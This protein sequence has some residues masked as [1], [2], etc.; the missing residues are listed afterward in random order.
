MNI[1]SSRCQCRIHYFVS[2]QLPSVVD[3]DSEPPGFLEPDCLRTLGSDTF[4][5]GDLGA[6]FDSR[7]VALGLDQGW[8]FLH[9]S[10]RE[11]PAFGRTPATLHHHYDSCQ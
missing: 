9:F 3:S 8:I 1:M 5:V 4:V 11:D 6:L 2:P 10:Y 7:I